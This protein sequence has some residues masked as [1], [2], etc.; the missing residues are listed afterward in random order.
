M[1]SGWSG[2]S[3]SMAGARWCSS[4]LAEGLVDAAPAPDHAVDLAP[5][6][7]DIGQQAVIETLEL[8]LGAGQAEET[9]DALGEPVDDLGESTPAD[10]AAS[11]GVDGG[12]RHLVLSM[13]FA[14]IPTCCAAQFHDEVYTYDS[15]VYQRGQNT[16]AMHD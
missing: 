11:G 16:A 2:E 10:A 3:E 13:H 12:A 8:A 5:P 9:A 7:A 1:A 6:Q 14:A 4:R 15:A